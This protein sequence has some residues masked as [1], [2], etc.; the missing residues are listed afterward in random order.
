MPAAIDAQVDPAIQA[1]IEQ[2]MQGDFAF[3]FNLKEM[4]ENVTQY[5]AFHAFYASSREE[6][7]ERYFAVITPYNFSDT[8]DNV[9]FN[10]NASTNCLVVNLNDKEGGSLFVKDFSDWGESDDL[11]RLQGDTLENIF[12]TNTETIT[13]K[14]VRHQNAFVAEVVEGETE[15]AN[16]GIKPSDKDTPPS[17]HADTIERKNQHTPARR[18]KKQKGQESTPASE[19]KDSTPDSHEAT[20]NDKP[21][22]KGIPRGP[23]PQRKTSKTTARIPSE[24]ENAPPQKTSL[25]KAKVQPAEKITTPATGPRRSPRQTARPNYALKFGML[26]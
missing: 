26:L 3:V 20:K 25:K 17:K 2:T 22:R 16:P 5:M 4:H 8:S 12:K 1:V 14:R 13:I 24:Q 15:P 11:V 7:E 21:K 23:S 6:Q 18:E 10:V 19:E 9:L